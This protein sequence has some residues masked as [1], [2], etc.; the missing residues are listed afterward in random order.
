M[1]NLNPAGIELG[2]QLMTCSIV[3]LFGDC[4]SDKW[5]NCLLCKIPEHSEKC[6]QWHTVA[7][8]SVCFRWN[9]TKRE[10]VCDGWERERGRVC[11]TLRLL[12]CHIPSSL[13]V[14]HSVRASPVTFSGSWTLGPFSVTLCCHS[15]L[16]QPRQWCIRTVGEKMIHSQPQGLAWLKVVFPLLHQ[17]QLLQAQNT[18]HCCDESKDVAM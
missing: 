12:F 5:G 14:W 9:D 1:C 11:S 4:F 15:W 17:N 7:L 18:T 10:I 2:L 8:L 3:D 6:N 16:L 13:P